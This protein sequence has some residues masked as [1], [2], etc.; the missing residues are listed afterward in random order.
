ML[1][2]LIRRLSIGLLT[3]LLI[4]FGVYGLVRAMPGS[5]LTI[6]EDRVDLKRQI[7]EADRKEM[8][9]QYGLDKPWPVAYVV[10][11]ADMARGNM[12]KSFARKRPVSE[13]IGER[14]G[15]TLLLS[16]TSLLLAYVISV[17]LGLLSVARSGKWD[18]RFIG[19]SLYVLYSFPGFVAALLLQLVVAVRLNWLPLYGMKSDEYDTFS[20]G[21][22]VWDILQHSV[23]PIVVFTYGSLAYYTRFIHANMQE[24]IRQDYI[25]TAQAK[26]LGPFAVIV[27]HAF[28]NTLIP[29]VTKIGLSLPALLSGSVII[30]RIFNWPG[31]GQLFFSAIL[32]RDY[33]VIMALTLLF[34]VLTLAGQLLA[35]L[36]YALVDPRVR[37]EDS[38]G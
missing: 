14:L 23:L 28:R 20:T 27:K 37:I 5:P 36:L 24:V 8:M 17:P 10:W 16:T 29:F 11:V 32:E 38:G 33:N 26:G 2:F 30:E 1:E 12:G 15:P 13:V 3:L 7:S 21:G 22:K 6:A 34:S 19:I 4:T 35:D 9:K 25:R 18:E 31:L